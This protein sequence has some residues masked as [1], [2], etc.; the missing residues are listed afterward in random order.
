MTRLRNYPFLKN[1]FADDGKY[2]FYDNVPRK[3]Q[4]IYLGWISAVY[5]KGRALWKKSHALWWDHHSIIH[6]EFSNHSQLLNVDLYTQNL[7][8]VHEN[9]LRKHSSLIK[10]RNVV[11][12]FD[13]VRSHS[14]RITQEKILDL[15]WFVLKHP[16]Y[17]PDL[18]PSDFHLFCSQQN[19]LNDKTFSQEEQV[20]I[21]GKLLKL[22]TSWI[23]LERKPDKWQEVIQNNSKYTIGWN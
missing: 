12:L 19:A 18:A 16:Q 21:Y 22:K 20:K 13:Y 1:I 15:G 23:L 9:H 10:R 4:W 8:S 5:L 14:A 3:K 7:Q 2:V 17:S 11:L 6:F